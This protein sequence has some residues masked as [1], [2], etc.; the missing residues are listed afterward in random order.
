MRIHWTLLAV[1]T[2]AATTADASSLLVLETGR[3]G[4][5]QAASVERLDAGTAGGASMVA[6]G[7]PAAE[8][9]SQPAP[10]GRLPLVMRGGVTGPAMSGRSPAPPPP[11][12]PVATAASAPA[13]AA[14]NG[15]GRKAENRRVAEPPASPPPVPA[16]LP[17]LDAPQ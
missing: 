16:A 8:D 7:E 4:I 2:V 14:G 5:P 11:A 15:G 1:A 9:A 6:L 17:R 10:R 12:P 13:A 3:T